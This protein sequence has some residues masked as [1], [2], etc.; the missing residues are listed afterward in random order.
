MPQEHREE[1]TPQPNMKPTR[2]IWNFL[3][4]IAETALFDRAIEMYHL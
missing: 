2:S 1:I 3:S 4:R